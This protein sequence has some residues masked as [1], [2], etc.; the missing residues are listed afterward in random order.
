MT[1]PLQNKLHVTNGDCAAELITQTGLSGEILA[2]RDMLHEGSVPANLS[3][4]QLRE[5][6]ARFIADFV[7]WTNYQETIEIF[8]HRDNTVE[9]FR[10]YEEIIL[11]FEHDLYDQL[12]LIQ[13]LDRFSQW[14]L[15]QTKLSLRG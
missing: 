5:I 12:Q 10:Q 9:N 1:S 14:D 4:A 8:T 6:R 2:W 11:W 7:W 15:G 13:I 3:S